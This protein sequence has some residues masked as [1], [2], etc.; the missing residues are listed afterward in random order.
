[1]SGLP[2]LHK[3][4]FTSYALYLLVYLVEGVTYKRGVLE[5]QFRVERVPEL[6]GPNASFEWSARTP[7]SFLHELCS[8]FKLVYLVEGITLKRGVLEVQFRVERVL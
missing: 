2:E 5:E 4:S 8:L 7:Q 1:M 3:V 6:L